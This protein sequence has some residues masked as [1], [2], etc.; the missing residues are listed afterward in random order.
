M[1]RRHARGQKLSWH[2]GVS[3]GARAEQTST[4]TGATVGYQCAAAGVS[5]Q[6]NEIS[7]DYQ[8]IS[9]AFVNAL[10]HR[11][12]D[13]VPPLFTEDGVFDRMGEQFKG[14]DAIR[15]WLPTRPEQLTMR[16]VCTN[17]EV[18]PIND[19]RVRGTTYFTVYRVLEAG[20]GPFTFTGPDLMGEYR[21]IIAREGGKWLFTRRE[22]QL[23][24]KKN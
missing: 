7:A 20:S 6:M 5:M 1:P 4:P 10:D 9:I 13:R 19:D 8:R 17:F 2:G 21:D 23:V 11:E 16:H 22:I 15:N 14:R 3:S 12:Y 24:F 18:I